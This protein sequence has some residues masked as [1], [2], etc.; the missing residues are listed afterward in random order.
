[1]GA[2]SHWSSLNPKSNNWRWHTDV[3]V[4][5][6][7]LVTYAGAPTLPRDELLV[8]QARTRS[9][10]FQGRLQLVVDL[11]QDG[12]PQVLVLPG[13]RDKPDPYNLSFRFYQRVEGGF[14]VPEDAT[15]TRV[16][17][18]VLENGIDGPRS[19]QSVNLS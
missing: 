14:Q 7:G 4:R 19:S 18:R 16:Q 8:V 12:R 10:E 1:M 13:N 5:D 9:K 11:L 17:V 2:K 15:V 3:V 6:V